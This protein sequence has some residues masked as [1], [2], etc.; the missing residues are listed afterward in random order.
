L[1]YP[2]SQVAQRLGDVSLRRLQRSVANLPCDH[3]IG[4][5][6]S[7]PTLFIGGDPDVQFIDRR[8]S[9]HVVY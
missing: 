6:D 4:G 2:S 8:L 7:L 1:L 3:H 5:H 9:G